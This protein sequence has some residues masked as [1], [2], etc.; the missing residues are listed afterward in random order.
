MLAATAQG[1]VSE[2]LAVRHLASDWKE[3][4]MF[5]LKETMYQISSKI[6]KLFKE[7][8]YFVLIVCH[9]TNIN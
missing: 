8:K 9:R 1:S 2:Y 4:S 6:L 3:I 5:Q 7:K